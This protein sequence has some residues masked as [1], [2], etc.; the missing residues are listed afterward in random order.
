MHYIVLIL[1]Q[2]VEPNNLLTFAHVAD[3]GSFSRAAERMRVPKS[4]V[5]RRVAALEKQLGERLL[6]RTTRKLTLTDLGLAV[7]EHARA[8]AA[9]VEATRA[10]VLQRQ[11]EPSGRLRVSMTNDIAESL[12]APMLARFTEQYPHVLL[13]LDLTSR[14]VD[15]VGEGF[16][17]ALRW[18]SL[19]AD[20]SLVV[21]RI[22]TMRAGLYAAPAYLAAHGEPATPNDLLGLHALQIPGRDGPPSPWLLQRGAADAIEHW[23]GLAPARALVNSPAV[24]LQLAVA[25]LGVTAAAE[26]QAARHVE[27]GELRRILPDWCSPSVPGWLVLPGRRLMPAKTR[28]FAAALEGALETLGR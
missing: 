9:E 19:P 3:A 24:L 8:L 18:G 1:E 11:T 25:G 23:Q 17:L 21:R 7:L 10:L 2:L 27:R 12:L 13:E 28:V 22:C 14:R 26:W 6:L 5:S 20:S 15:L 16:D 4:T